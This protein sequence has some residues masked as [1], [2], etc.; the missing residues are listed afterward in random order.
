MAR[1]LLGAGLVLA[2]V[3]AIGRAAEPAPLP[4]P[5]PVYPRFDL[6]Y[7][8]EI[9]QGLLGLRPAEIVRHAKSPE[10]KS[11]A[12]LFMLLLGQMIPDAD[13][14]A[15]KFPDLADIEQ[16]VWNLNLKITTPTPDAQGS[17]LFGWVTPCVIRTVQPFDWNDHVR[18]WFPKAAAKRIA[19]RS[20]VRIKIEHPAEKGEAPWLGSMAFFAPDERTL[21][22]AAEDDMFEL[23]DRLAEGKPAPY[24]SAGLGRGGSGDCRV[25]ARH[26][27][28]AA[29]ERHVPAGLPLGQG[30][31]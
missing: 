7:L 25:R 23:L 17:F 16:C 3:P 8:P 11:I 10:L 31:G 14:D 2:L 4:R 29:A 20:Y 12:A 19:G 26:A 13:F 27:R 30:P 9:G 22:I 18:K 1:L 21:V 6:T 24:A 5:V 15:A 28:G